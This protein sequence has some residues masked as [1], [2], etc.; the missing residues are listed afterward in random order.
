M[1]N[2]ALNKWMMQR[3]SAIILIP[4]LLF[5]LY[6]LVNLVNLD[7]TGAI[8]YFENYFSVVIFALF[9]I[10]AGLH[11]KLGLNEIIEDYIHDEKIKIFLNRVIILYSALLPVVGIISLTTVIL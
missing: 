11:L 2:Y 8:D 5:F 6:S 10:F 4:L 7:Y 9:L 1:K 3:V